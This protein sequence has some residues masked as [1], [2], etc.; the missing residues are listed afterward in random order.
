MKQKL[1]VRKLQVLEITLNGGKWHVKA[2][3]PKGK[4]QPAIIR[5]QEIKPTAKH[6]P[7]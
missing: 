4:R 1:K 3:V 5:H 7:V 6:I 2:A